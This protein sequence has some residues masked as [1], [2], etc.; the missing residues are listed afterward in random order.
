MV[1]GVEKVL[2]IQEQ[3]SKN[4]IIV[5]T[6]SKKNLC[7]Q[8]T[9]STTERQTITTMLLKNEKFYL[10]HNSFSE[11]IPIVV[12]FKAMGVECDQEIAQL[13]G[14]EPQYLEA[15]ALSLQECSMLKVLTKKSALD[16]ISEKTKGAKKSGQKSKVEEAKEIMETLIVSHVPC[17][18]EN[19]FPKARYLALMIRRIVEAK[20]DPSKLDDRDYYGNKRL[21]LAGALIS[22][23]FQDLFKKFTFDL[24]KDIERNLPKQR[25]REEFDAISC[26]RQDALTMGL[27]NAIAT[28]NWSLKRFKMER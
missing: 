24:E 1:R 3:M 23:L 14:T 4:R 7:A 18:K 6:D 27:E 17:S 8:V 25:R 20:H 22:L 12:A 15:I 9:S 21:E 26:I 28:G 2:L 10:K 11:D 19:F 5:E 13:I 16:Y